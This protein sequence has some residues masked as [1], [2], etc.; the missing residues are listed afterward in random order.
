MQVFFFFFWWSG[1][2]TIKNRTCESD[3]TTFNR[4]RAKPG[5]TSRCNC[6]SQSNFTGSKQTI[7]NMALRREAY[8]ARLMWRQLNLIWLFSLF[9]V[10]SVPRRVTTH[11]MA[12]NQTHGAMNSAL[13]PQENN[14][15]SSVQETS[16][17]LKDRLTN[18]T[19]ERQEKLKAEI[20]KTIDGMFLF[21]RA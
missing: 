5:T 8:P 10:L 6:G 17:S 16:A 11:R 1:Q 13:V 2:L 12:Y 21:I 18:I 3:C 9:H 7:Q 19:L 14:S 15:D 20:C 4:P